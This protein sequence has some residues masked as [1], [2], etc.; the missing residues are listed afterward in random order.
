MPSQLSPQWLCGNSCTWH[1]MYS[2]ILLVPMNQRVLNKQ[3]KERNISGHKWFTTHRVHKSHRSKIGVIYM[4]LWKQ[5]ALPVITTI[6]LWQ[7]IHLSTWCL[8]CVH[9]LMCISHVYVT[10][11][12]TSCVQVNDLPQSYCGDNQEG[13]LSSWF[14]IYYTRLASVRFE[15]SVCHGSLI[16]TYIYNIY[17]QYM[18]ININFFIWCVDVNIGEKKKYKHTILKILTYSKISTLKRSPC[19]TG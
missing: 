5:Y 17:I 1:M 6:A 7:L 16:T 19:E 3:S 10:S 9:H 2:Y 8:P 15:H 13:T 11:N 18:C 12:C 14:H 4:Q